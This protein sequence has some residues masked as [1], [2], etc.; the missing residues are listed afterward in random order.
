VTASFAPP[1]RH[2]L[3]WRK[4][5]RKANRRP[6]EAIGYIGRVLSANEAPKF[7][8]VPY[9]I[10]SLLILIAP[11]FFSASVYM[12]LGRI[13]RMVHGEKHSIIRT[14]WLT[15]VFVTS[16]VLSFF[17]QSGGGG[18]LATA[19][20]LDGFRRGEM[21]IIAGLFVQLVGF[22]LFLL[23]IALF[24]VR[25]LKAP[26]SASLSATVPW[27][28]FLLV[29]Y[30]VSALILIRSVFRAIEYIMGYDSVLQNN[31]YYLYI[32]D[33][34]LMFLCMAALNI[35]HPSQIINAVGSS[36]GSGRESGGHKPL[37]SMAGSDMELRG[38]AYDPEAGQ[39]RYDGEY[40]PPSSG[41]RK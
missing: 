32:F 26:T 30:F 5:T 31:E 23:V 29:L 37:D 4:E 36:G 41:P 40:R 38:N 35:W 27:R 3:R 15:K 33:A 7:T 10:Q 13:I 34:A 17:L 6:V 16:D 12:I 8:K 22:F 28:R 1:R 21:I 19:K 24:H 2:N 14:N 20:D 18:I 9:I 25:I 39:G 11:A